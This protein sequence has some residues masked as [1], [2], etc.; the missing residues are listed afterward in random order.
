MYVSI[1]E[2]N[3]GALFLGDTLL[4]QS[5]QQTLPHQDNLVLRTDQEAVNQIVQN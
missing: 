2:D 1:H 5:M 3:A 4:P